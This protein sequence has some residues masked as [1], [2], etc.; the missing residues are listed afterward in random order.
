MRPVD[1]CSASSAPE[2]SEQRHQQEAQAVL[3][4]QPWK[5]RRITPAG[6]CRQTDV[7]AG[8]S[9]SPTWPATATAAIQLQ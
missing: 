6:E 2:T 1:P 8:S 9:I 5:H 7:V 3:T 4:V